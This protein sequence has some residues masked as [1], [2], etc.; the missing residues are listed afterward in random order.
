MDANREARSAAH[1]ARRAWREGDW[2]TCPRCEGQNYDRGSCGLCG[3]LGVLDE[4]GERFH[5]DCRADDWVE[6]DN[7]AIRCERCGGYAGEPGTSIKL[8][9]ARKVDILRALAGIV[10]GPLG[11]RAP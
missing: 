9:E 3:N 6:G 11:R 8:V 2:I 5:C 1:T 10:A 4:N 7:G